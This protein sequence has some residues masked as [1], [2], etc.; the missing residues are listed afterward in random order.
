MKNKQI[1]IGIIAK[2]PKA[3]CDNC[4]YGLS[5]TLFVDDLSAVIFANGAIPIG[6]LPPDIGIHK[7]NDL[8]DPVDYELDKKAI[9]NLEKSLALCNGIIIQGGYSNDHYELFVAKY[10][11]DNDIPLLGICAGHQVMA[12]AMGG[13]TAKMK[14]DTHIKPWLDKRHG[15]FVHD[16]F[17]TPKTKL[18]KIIGNTKLGVN[19]SHGFHVSELPPGYVVSAVDDDGN[20]EA[21]EA[22]NK[23]FNL[24]VQW[25]PECLYAKSKKHN[26]IF[27][28]L[29]DASRP[30]KP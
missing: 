9:S 1:V 23:R 14:T 19:S 6:I 18:H 13:K 26:A 7:R 4:H 16:V 21:M 5:G 10:C 29:I 17:I 22:L 8:F 24:S 3:M 27:K 25:H 15:E 12:H 28:A 11:Y 30:L 20:I 2:H